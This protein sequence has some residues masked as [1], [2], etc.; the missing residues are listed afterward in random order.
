MKAKRLLAWLLTLA[1]LLSV[2]S[3]FGCAKNDGAAEE[4]AAQGAEAEEPAGRTTR[5]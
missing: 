5:T 4:P 2:T 3:V 1:L